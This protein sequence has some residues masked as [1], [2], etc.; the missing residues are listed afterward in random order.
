MI[1]IE[2]I[3]YLPCWVLY[4]DLIETKNNIENITFYNWDSINEH[5]LYYLLDMYKKN[6]NDNIDIIIN[7]VKTII[8]D[9]TN[10]RGGYLIDEDYNIHI[11]F[12]LV[13]CENCGNIWD[14]NAQCNCY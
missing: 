13:E 5:T 11:S 1:L 2:H 3:Y 9:L 8:I 7:L 14:G 4:M 6:I 12:E 10:E